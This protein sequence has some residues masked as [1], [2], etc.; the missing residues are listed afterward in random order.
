[1]LTEAQRAAVLERAK[2]FVRAGGAISL[3]DWRAMSE[4]ERAI[5]SDAAGAVFAERLDGALGL[6]APPAKAPETGMD[7]LAERALGGIMDGI[8]ERS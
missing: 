7:P 5:M 1:M 6:L 2:A 3:A 4:D 8:E